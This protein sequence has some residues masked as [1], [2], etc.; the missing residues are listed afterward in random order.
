MKRHTALVSGNLVAIWQAGAKR[1]TRCDLY[2]SLGL[3]LLLGVKLKQI[4]LLFEEHMLRSFT[5][6]NPMSLVYSKNAVC[7]VTAPKCCE[8]TVFQ[9]HLKTH[10]RKSFE[11]CSLVGIDL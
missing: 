1:H 8:E 3:H 11:A 10:N 9:H 7:N 5:L 2:T 6:I 4:S